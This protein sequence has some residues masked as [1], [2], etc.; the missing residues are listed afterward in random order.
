MEYGPDFIC[1]GAQKSGTSWLHWNL[2]YHPGTEMPPEKKINFY[3]TDFCPWWERYL[4]NLFVKHSSIYLRLRNHYISWLQDTDKKDTLEWYKHFLFLPPTI[5]NYRKLFPKPCGKV[6]GDIAPGYARLPKKRIKELAKAFPNLKVIYLLRNPVDRTWSQFKMENRDLLLN[7]KDND[8]FDILKYV[9]NIKYRLLSDYK[10]SLEHW[11]HF[12]PGR[13]K[14]WFY[15]Q[16][17][18]N[19]ENVFIEICEYLNISPLIDFEHNK[20]RE[21]VFEG[22]TNVMPKNVCQYLNTIFKEDILFLQSRFNNIYTK[23]WLDNCIHDLNI[24]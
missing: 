7:N 4:F 15:D 2:F 11:E 14:V 18:E 17:C 21:K 9:M 8:N 6:C 24:L 22:S 20:I 1:I 10:T 23:K 16:L 13:V 12:F 5:Q 3:L 19:S